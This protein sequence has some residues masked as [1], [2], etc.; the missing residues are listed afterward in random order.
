MMVNKQTIQDISLP[1]ANFDLS[2][3]LAGQG[4][5]SIFTRFWHSKSESQSRYC[6]VMLQPTYVKLHHV[7]AYTKLEL[8]KLLERNWMFL[9]FFWSYSTLS[10]SSFYSV[11]LWHT[12]VKLQHLIAYLK[13][14]EK[15]IDKMRN[16]AISN[17]LIIIWQF[18][19]WVFG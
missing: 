12:G 5:K 8:K 13:V 4:L 17:I 3:I 1:G 6:S 11:M 16:E 10:Q 14:G 18:L 15:C 9:L 2:R 19:I 7:I